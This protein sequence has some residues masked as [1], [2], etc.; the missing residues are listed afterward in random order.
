METVNEQTV[1]P[2]RV[3][4]VVLAAWNDTMCRLTAAVTLMSVEYFGFC[5]MRSES[6]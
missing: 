6:N 5:S 4:V 1:M 2:G 3:A